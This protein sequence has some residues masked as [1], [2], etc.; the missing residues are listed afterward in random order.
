MLSIG[1]FP[2]RNT[3]I[4]YGYSYSNGEKYWL[5]KIGIPAQAA[6][7]A[8]AAA[9]APGPAWRF[10]DDAFYIFTDDLNITLK[11]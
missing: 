8:A 5:P 3:Q 7:A 6:A 4:C 10:S 11:K 9:A 1:L 2:G